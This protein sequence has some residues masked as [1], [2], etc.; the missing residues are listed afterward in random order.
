MSK[1]TYYG[2]VMKNGHPTK[3]TTFGTQ[4]TRRRQTNKTKKT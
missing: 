2:R 4:D 1:S 3:L